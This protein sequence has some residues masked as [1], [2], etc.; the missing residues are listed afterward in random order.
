[1]EM[2]GILRAGDVPLHPRCF[3]QT[4]GPSQVTPKELW[5]APLAVGSGVG[6]SAIGAISGPLQSVETAAASP[7]MERARLGAGTGDAI[8]TGNGHDGTHRPGGKF[9]GN[10]GD[11]QQISADDGERAPEH[12]CANSS[13]RVLHPGSC[14]ITARCCTKLRAPTTSQPGHEPSH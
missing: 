12:L 2:S 11:Q 8:W 5:A 9:G 6:C 3:G 7:R 13:R 10:H 4:T 14:T 1:V